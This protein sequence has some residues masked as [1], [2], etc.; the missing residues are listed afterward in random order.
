M[1][2]PSHKPYWSEKEQKNI[3]DALARGQISGDGCYTELVSAF[4]ENNYGVKKV[5]M[6]TSGTHALDMAA[7]LA[8]LEPDDEVIMPSFTFS[9]T[10]NAVLL[11]GAKPVFAEITAETLNID[12]DDIEN[13]ITVKTKAVI[14]V[15]YAGVAC[16][17]DR[18]MAIAAKHG[19]KVIEDAAQGVN[20]QY[21]GR[22]LGT[23]G[24]YGCYSFH[25]TKNYTCGE[26]GAL[27]INRENTQIIEKA[28]IIR[29]KG[30][31]R[32]HFLQGNVDK[33]NWLDTGS[34]YSPSDLLMAVLLAQLE[35]VPE[36]T[37]KRKAVYTA[38]R[39]AFEPYEKQGILKMMEI[40]PDCTPNYHIFWVIFSSQAIRDMVLNG[41]K[42]RGVAASFHFL[43]LHSSPMGETMEY[44]PDDLPVTENSAKC[45]LRLPLYA[46]MTEA[47]LHYV[48]RSVDA[49][50]RGM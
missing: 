26:G 9:S 22:Y 20:A 42:G 50:I 35:A 11:R 49:V 33:Y 8:G 16:D 24:D 30:T 31:N 32:C 19:L 48:I 6:T 14:P 36:I 44:Q 29:Q 45:L 18:I 7:I 47:E 43:P 10:A 17:M 41:L 34:S 28:E 38:Y 3:L 13:K 5:L 46:G 2:I 1:N 39:N 12:S 27:L 4:I 25:G 21:R 40:P 23:I 15:H 37:A